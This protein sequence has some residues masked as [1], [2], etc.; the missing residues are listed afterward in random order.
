LALS[1]SPFGQEIHNIAIS[2]FPAIRTSS[3]DQSKPGGPVTLTTFVAK[4][5]FEVDFTQSRLWL[6]TQPQQSAYNGDLT[7][8]DNPI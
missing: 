4:D 6:S 2:P 3:R 1:V 7:L 5:W 8:R